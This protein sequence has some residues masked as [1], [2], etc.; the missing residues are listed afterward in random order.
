MRSFL[1]VLIAKIADPTVAAIAI[2]GAWYFA[3]GWFSML[4][5]CLLAAVVQEALL[6]S[7]QATRVSFQP[8]P[9]ALGMIA[10]LV[11]ALAA[12]GIRFLI[13]FD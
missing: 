10:A 5:I 2:A 11:W 4:A 7:M 1:A 8:E 3:R 9:L 6:V 12:V 13:P